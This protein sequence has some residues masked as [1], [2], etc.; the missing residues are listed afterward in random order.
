MVIPARH[1]LALNAK[2]KIKN[3]DAFIV[4]LLFEQLETECSWKRQRD[5]LKMQSKYYM[6]CNDIFYVNRIRIHRHT[7]ALA[8]TS[9]GYLSMNNIWIVYL[10]NK[11]LN[12]WKYDST[13]RYC[14][15]LCET[16][17]RLNHKFLLRIFACSQLHCH[18]FLCIVSTVH[19]WHYRRLFIFRYR[20]HVFNSHFQCYRVH[21]TPPRFYVYTQ[22]KVCY[23]YTLSMRQ[24][25]QYDFKLLICTTVTRFSVFYCERITGS[26]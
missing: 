11:I 16:A 12:L 7:H 17:F 15:I 3:E 2:N 20:L 6:K 4:Y 10:C 14:T 13:L 26:L 21:V 5:I 24:C 18:S 1:F 19:V 9:S 23:S 25:L 8:F 22:F